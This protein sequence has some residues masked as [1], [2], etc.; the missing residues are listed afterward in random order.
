MWNQINQVILIQFLSLSFVFYIATHVQ[1]HI[2]MSL[3]EHSSINRLLNRLLAILFHFHPTFSRSIVRC[4]HLPS[5]TI[6][7]SSLL[8]CR[9]L[10]L[11][12]FHS[13]LFR[14]HFN[15]LFHLFHTDECCDSVYSVVVVAVVVSS[16]FFTFQ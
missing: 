9:W 13:F 11:C 2:L 14:W 1:T 16:L 12:Y 4:S 6:V 10:F 15:S 7:F 8:T 3:Y 5:S